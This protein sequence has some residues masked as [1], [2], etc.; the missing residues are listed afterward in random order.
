MAGVLAQKLSWRWIFWFLVIL[1]GAYFVVV[2]LLLPE[3]Q[4]RVVGNGSVKATGVHRSLFDLVSRDRKTADN[5]AQAVRH[6]RKLFVPNPFKCIAMLFFKGNSTVIF[7]GSITYLIKMTLQ[8]SLAAQCID[9]YGLDYL[10]AGLVYLPSG[11]GGAIASYITGK[12]DSP[13]SE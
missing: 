11:I 8:T 9:V 2:T 6:G 1:T 12:R 5:Q 4:R 3:T 13:T 10:Q 7:I